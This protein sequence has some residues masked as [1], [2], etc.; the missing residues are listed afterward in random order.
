MLN[1]EYILTLT[2]DFLNADFTS[3]SS[4]DNEVALKM[5]PFIFLYNST[6]K[7]QR[8]LDFVMN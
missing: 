4:Y 3:K 5:P 8:S 2:S 1:W 6:K 7:E